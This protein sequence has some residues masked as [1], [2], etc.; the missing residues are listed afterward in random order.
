MMHFFKFKAE[1]NVFILHYLQYFKL[2]IKVRVPRGA[3]IIKMWLYE[4]IA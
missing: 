2:Y 3:C 4:D 1:T